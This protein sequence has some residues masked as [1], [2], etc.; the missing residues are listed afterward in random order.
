L[1]VTGSVQGST[2]QGGG[3][4]TVDTGGYV[5]L[6]GAGQINASPQCV[7][8]SAAGSFTQSGGTNA[9]S[10]L[11]LGCNPGA[12]GI[13]VLSGSGQFSIVSQC[14]GDSGTG[15]FLQSGG[16][17][18]TSSGLYLGYAS[19]GNGTYTLSGSGQLSAQSAVVGFSGTGTFTQSGG[20]ANADCLY[21]GLLSGSSGTYNL[22]G[23]T[24]AV[25]YVSGGS[26]AGAF[27]FNG[28]LLQA[29]G[30]AA[31]AFLGGL[32][33]AY[34]QSGGA[35]I[36]TNGQNITIAQP[37]LDGG[38][39]GGLTKI[40]SGTLIL[41]GSNVYTGGTSVTGGLLEIGSAGGLP[42]GTSLTIGSGAGA[43]FDA[44]D[45]A[46][47]QSS[48][49]AAME[50]LVVASCADTPWVPSAVPAASSAIADDAGVSSV[51]E[52]GTLV[53]LGVGAVG[54]IGWAWRRGALA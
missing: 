33:G 18:T 48:T 37:L 2:P 13:Y 40:G 32:T 30:G 36:D 26:G 50:S 7:G 46:G 44:G 24:L 27:N 12:N 6:S 31:S 20:T 21:L 29:A 11:D 45:S 38:G 15:S 39:G 34:V 14:I 47:G 49:I 8:Y 52:P 17:S 16:T 9:G 54:L 19:G 41:T 5:S 28:G 25:A 4:L 10:Y 3:P 53:L 35:K 43:V 1:A 22:N 23:G 42:A 51:P